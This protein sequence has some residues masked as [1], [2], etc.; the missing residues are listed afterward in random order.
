MSSEQPTFSVSDALAV[1][2]QVLE[3]SMPSITVV[4]EVSSF[5]VNQG[6]WV[7][8]DLK[9]DE[10]SLNCFMSVYGLR[11]P[12]EDGMKI[13]VVAQPKLTKW[14]KFSLTVQSVRPIGEGSLK[15][16]FELLKAKLDKEGLFAADRKRALPELP[17]K[18]GVISSV[19]AA[20]YADF[21]KILD[22]R[23][24]GINI[25]VA[26][27]QVQ[28]AVAPE[29]IIRALEY[30]NGCENPPEVIAIIRGGGS[31][32]DLA[33]FNDEPLVWAIASSRVP[34]IVGVGHEIDESL[35]D[36]AA[37][38]RAATPS[39]AAQILVPDKREI[40]ADI[41]ARLR[42]LITNVEN[43]LDTVL[44][45]VSDNCEKMS[46]EASQ[47]LADDEA[48]FSQL[49]AV[50]KQLDPRMALRRGYSLVRNSDGKLLRD[51]PK[52]GDELRIENVVAKF[53]TTVTKI[54]EKSKSAS[55]QNAFPAEQVTP[56]TASRAASQKKVSRVA[57][58]E[59]L[60]LLTEEK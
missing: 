1:I 15:R 7:F 36:L 44:R 52:V 18:I 29:Q 30:F 58:D 12:L 4:G 22:Q 5:K 10:A 26:N 6:K 50:L 37:D 2:N 25:E 42:H 13:A 16:A 21:I 9:D 54:I 27:V 53:E 20:G 31:A 17:A 32:D 28:G 55:S 35:A 51:V 33:A 38:V 41:D 34:T 49:H 57:T 8:F 60:N 40:V 47:I 11:I 3:Y 39:N 46:R 56:E 14:G 48:R 43:N 24:G 45:N 19:A 59:K 23:F